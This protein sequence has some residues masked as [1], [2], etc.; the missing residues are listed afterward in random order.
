MVQWIIICI[1]GISL[2]AFLI[3]KMYRIFF[4]K[5]YKSICRDCPLGKE[6]NKAKIL[7]DACS[8]NGRPGEE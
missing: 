3:Y 5:E 6:C 8:Q 2:L 7:K 1:I 4:Y